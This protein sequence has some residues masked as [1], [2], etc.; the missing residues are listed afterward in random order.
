M[1]GRYRRGFGR[2]RGAMSFNVI[3]SIKNIHDASFGISGSGNT[4]NFA[5]AVTTPSP[6]VDS[7]VA[8][9]CVIKA[10]WIS[11]DVC[12]LGG[13][14]VLNNADIFLMKNP[15]N[16]LTPPGADAVG[17]SNEKKFVF[18][19]WHAMIMRNQDGNVPYHWEGWIKI[20]K[21]YWRMG[22][23]DTLQLVVQ[24]TTALTGHF[25]YQAIYKWYT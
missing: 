1:P 9:G 3:R 6:T 17:T 10:V 21:R 18:K 11:L 16:N 7:D 14:G 23:D 25:S 2:R 13:T 24:C 5:K 15:G 4:N 22:T 8:H 20:P 19:Q 12:G